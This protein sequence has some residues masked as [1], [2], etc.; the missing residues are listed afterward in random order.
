MA[1]P[2]PPSYE[3]FYPSSI[4]TRRTSAR[5]AS[6][7]TALVPQKKSLEIGTFES[8]NDEYF[9]ESDAP[10]EIDDND[11]YLPFADHKKRKSLSIARHSANVLIKKSK[12]AKKCDILLLPIELLQWIFKHT[13]P[14]TLGRLMGVCRQF[15][16]ILRADES[17]SH[18]SLKESNR[19]FGELFENIGIPACSS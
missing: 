2:P 1:C 19:R 15:S 9:S 18:Q 8:E 5:L 12:H 11:E 13:E 6:K 3:E 4:T 7:S 10:I 14:K 17:V 16:Q